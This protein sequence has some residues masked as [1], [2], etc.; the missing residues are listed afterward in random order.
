MAQ[1]LLYVGSDGFANSFNGKMLEKKLRKIMAQGKV[2]NE[3]KI[4]CRSE[5]KKRWE[6]LGV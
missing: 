3:E 4:K 5:K 6:E 1:S 2:K